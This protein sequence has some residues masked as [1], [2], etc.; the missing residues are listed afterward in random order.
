VCD[1]FLV[2][3]VSKSKDWKTQIIL[4]FLG[5]I[6]LS[7]AWRSAFSKMLFKFDE[8]THKLFDKAPN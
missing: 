6:K 1:T 4:K 8:I 7:S 2:K 3:S 5:A